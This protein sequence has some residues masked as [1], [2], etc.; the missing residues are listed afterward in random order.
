MK[1]AKISSLTSRNIESFQTR[2][3]KTPVCIVVT[4]YSKV[5]CYRKIPDRR[6]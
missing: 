6:A 1:D 3:T 4:I 5:R 2:T